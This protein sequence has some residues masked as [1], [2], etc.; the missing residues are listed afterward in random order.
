M[1]NTSRPGGA[2][3]AA[4]FQS[5]ST[6]S[7]FRVLADNE[8]VST[9]IG[10]IRSNCSSSLDSSLSSTSPSPYGGYPLPEQVVQYYRASS[11]A[12]TLDGYNDS[13][14]FAPDGT[15]DTP[16]PSGVD[17]KLMDCMNQTIGLAAPLVDGGVGLTVPNLGLLGLLY[18]V[19]NLLSLV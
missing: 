1:S 18:V 14:V 2:M 8:T 12:L 17:T 7:I 5:S 6:S 16:L 19:W 13:A 11:I 3:A 4:A 9:L 10:D 15:P